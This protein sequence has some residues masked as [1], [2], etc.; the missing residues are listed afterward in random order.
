MPSR[1][2][3]VPVLSTEGLHGAGAPLGQLGPV[4]LR[5]RTR[6]PR[7]MHIISTLMVGHQ[8]RK[9]LQRRWVLRP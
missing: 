2:V 1:P 9:P 8:I 4:G 7:C 6:H 5:V 3:W